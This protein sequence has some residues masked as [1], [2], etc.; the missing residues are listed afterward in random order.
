MQRFPQSILQAASGAGLRSKHV[1]SSIRYG[2]PPGELRAAGT[3]LRRRPGAALS[4]QVREPCRWETGW[5]HSEENMRIIVVYTVFHN[6]SGCGQMLGRSIEHELSSLI[7]PEKGHWCSMQTP[8]C[9]CT[10]C[11][12]FAP[13]SAGNCSS[14]TFWGPGCGAVR[15]PKKLH[16]SPTP[17]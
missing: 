16:D 14:R 13:A 17:G 7:S 10:G 9:A 12:C 3:T 4:S 5:G 2:L 11:C 6:L 1:V 8:C 15:C